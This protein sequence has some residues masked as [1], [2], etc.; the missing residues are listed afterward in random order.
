MR[1][2]PHTEAE[3]SEMLKTAGAPNLD[4]LFSS[5]PNGLRLKRELNL[6]KPMSEAELAGHLNSLG[7]KNKTDF[8]SF[9]GAGAYRHFTPAAVSMITGRSEF[10]TPYTPYQPEISQ[11]TLQTVFEY[12]S[13]ICRLF[14]MDISN[15][16]HYD[17][18]TST[19]EAALL[20]VRSTKRKK[21]LVS[22]ALHPEYRATM[23]TILRPS[24]VEFVTVPHTQ[25]GTIDRNKLKTLCNKEVAGLIVSYPNFFG[26]VDELADMADLIH[27]AGGVFVVSV[28][29]PT[30]MGIVEAPGNLGADIV[31][32]E[33]QAFGCGVNFGGPYLGIF[34][35]KEKFLRQVPGRIVGQT[36]DSDGR[37]GFVLTFATRE[38]HIRRE[39]ATSN[40][41]SNEALCAT[42]AAVYLSLLG[43]EGLCRLAEVNYARAEYAKSLARKKGLKIR[44]AGPTFNEFVLDV[45]SAESVL[46]KL[47]QNGVFGGVALGRWYPQY[48]D[49]ILVC[50]TEMN[51]REEIEK[52]IG[53]L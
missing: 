39:K 3:I 23:E 21:L 16:S 46:K 52:L 15:A 36:V 9:L 14:A 34:A 33:G 8:I 5:I 7:K 6:P 32:A 40:I 2:L 51:A 11:G 37:R 30:S 45:D 12:Q 35:A 42:T 29:E 24:A 50:V 53:L 28:P 49:C 25:E 4:G 38:Q 17:G 26:V 27:D 19:A 47:E 48:K 1:Y 41:C 18:A 20:A 43:K 44:F 22:D 31:C 10:I 13:M